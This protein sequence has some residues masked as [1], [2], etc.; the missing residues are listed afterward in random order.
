MDSI[1]IEW[2][3]TL[4]AA[5][6][7]AS[8]AEL[9]PTAGAD[10]WR[11]AREDALDLFG[12]QFNREAFDNYF[13]EVGAWDDAELAAH[14]DAECAALMLQFIAGDI[15]ECEFI[16]YEPFSRQWWVRYEAASREGIVS[17]RFGRDDTGRVHYYIC[18]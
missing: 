15:R 11:A 3:N 4:P 18:N 8:M 13:R 5:D 2:A 16:D 6:Y 9:G 7:S 1:V 10:T 12:A 14:T 17:P